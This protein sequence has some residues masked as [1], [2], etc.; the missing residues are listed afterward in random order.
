MT[1]SLSIRKEAELDINSV[2]EYYEDRRIGLGH[3]FL[4][5]VEGALSKIARNPLQYK[6]IYKELRRI[7]V[8]RFPYRIFYFVEEHTVVVTA[9]FHARKDPQSWN[10]RT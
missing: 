1:Y 6:T 10:H 5:C 7:A 9:V 2:F 8:Y 3:D 4:L